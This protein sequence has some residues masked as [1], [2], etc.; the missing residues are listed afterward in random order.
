MR[1]R[2]YNKALF[3]VRILN[4]DGRLL[5]EHWMDLELGV[6]KCATYNPDATPLQVGEIPMELYLK[7]VQKLVAEHA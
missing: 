5:A 7:E 6:V 2:R 4:H 3:G 1:Q